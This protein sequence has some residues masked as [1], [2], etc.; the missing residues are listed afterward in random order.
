MGVC[1][2]SANVYAHV[3]VCVGARLFAHA[4]CMCPCARVPVSKENN[5][6]AIEDSVHDL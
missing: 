3:L 1:A 6:N 2:V 4:N 5:D